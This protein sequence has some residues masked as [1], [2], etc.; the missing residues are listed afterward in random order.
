MKKIFIGVLLLSFVS[1]GYAKPMTKKDITWLESQKAVRDIGCNEYNDRSYSKPKKGEVVIAESV[2]KVNRLFDES[3]LICEL[4]EDNDAF[5]IEVVE[6]SAI[7]GK[8]VYVY[9]NNSNGSVDVSDD[10]Y[11]NWAYKCQKDTM[12]DEVVCGMNQRGL[13]IEKDANGYR[14]QVGYEHFPETLA[15][16]RIDKEKPVESESNGIYSRETT[17]LI[18]GDL[19]DEKEVN[20]RYTKWPIQKPVDRKINMEGFNSA[21]KA[22]DIL[23]ANYR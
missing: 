14:M 5:I 18:I 1:I 19:S 12:T 3:T 13:T 22:I 21:K 6:Q 20:I 17:R 10:Y 11:N 4:N 23:Q 2:F 16:I 9:H 15:Y 8:K 7:D